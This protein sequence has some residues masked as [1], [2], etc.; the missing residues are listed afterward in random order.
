MRVTNNMLIN[1]LKKNINMGLSRM[2]RVHNQ[3][4]TGK[5]FSAPSDDPVGVARSLKLRVDLNENAQ[6]KKNAEDALSWLATSE[7][8]IMQIKDI[9]QKV[10]E[11][12]LQGANGVLVPEDSQKIAEEAIQLR[13]H[14]VSIGNS[15]YM[16]KH[17]FAGYKTDKMPVGLNEDGSLDFMG[18]EGEIMYQVGVSDMLRA[19]FSAKDLFISE[20]KDLLLDMQHFTEHLK[21]GNFEDVGS[22]IGDF[23]FHIENILA[24]VA[25]VGAKANRTELTVNRLGDEKLNFTTLLSQTEDADM[26][27]VIIR[28]KSEENVYMAALAGGARI[29]QPTLVDFLR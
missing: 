3:V 5:R 29:I 12:A 17:I 26:A 2:Q 28:L 13:D 4:E 23:D 25:E 27:E 18:D 21:A 20:G 7:T 8:A 6:F 22:M 19:N 10:R 9:L 16:G 14:L 1:N 24:K 15:T 11:L